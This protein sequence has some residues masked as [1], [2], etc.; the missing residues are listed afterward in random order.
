MTFIRDPRTCRRFPTSASTPKASRKELLTGTSEADPSGAVQH[1]PQ[2]AEELQ[3]PEDAQ[4]L[5]DAAEAHEAQEGQVEAAAAALRAGLVEGQEVQEV[6]EDREDH[7][8]NESKYVPKIFI[9]IILI[10]CYISHT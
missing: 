4:D 9:D 5:H 7:Q 2:L 10:Y 6:L 1:E 8:A 3:R